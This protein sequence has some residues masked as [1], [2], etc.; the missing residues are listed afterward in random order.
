MQKAIKLYQTTIYFLET[1][2]FSALVFFMR[3]WMAKI[4]WF[5]GL[6]KISSWPTTVALF[7]NLYKIP[8][9]PPTLAAFL[10]TATELTCPI[11]LTLGL[12]TRF[13]AIPMLIMTAVIQCTYA[14]CLDNAYWAFLLGTIFLYGPGRYSMDEWIETILKRRYETQAFF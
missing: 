5:S 2:C 13:A 8:V 11:L 4:F 6:T 12:A 10:S 14:P 7:T 9:I 3:L 1:Y